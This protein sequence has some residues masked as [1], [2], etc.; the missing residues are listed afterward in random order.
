MHSSILIIITVPIIIG[1]LTKKETHIGV[2]SIYAFCAFSF[3]FLIVIYIL[4]KNN[5][6]TKLNLIDNMNSQNWLNFL[7]TY[8]SAIITAASSS[9]FLFLITEHQINKSDDSNKENLRIQN[10][11]LLKYTFTNNVNFDKAIYLDIYKE[12]AENVAELK[13]IMKNVGLSTIKDIYIM[14]NNSKS[15]YK[16][17]NQNLIE[18][19]ESREIDF[20]FMSPKGAHKLSFIIY[21]KDILNNWYSQNIELNY[22]FTDY[23]RKIQIISFD[24]KDERLLEDK[25]LK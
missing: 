16:L 25:T 18:K 13:L 14:I 6:P 1:Y 19:E 10:I 21:Y 24:V 20:L 11:P 23:S 3:Y 4:D 15:K 5:I 9:L 2:K 7:A 12:M 8:L 22:E 17:D